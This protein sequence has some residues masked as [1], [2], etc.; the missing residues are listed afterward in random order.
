MTNDVIKGK[1]ILIIPAS[2]Q[3]YTIVEIAK[4]MGLYTIV[5]DYYDEEK[6]PAKKIAD[7]AY[8]ISWTDLDALEKLCREKQV[9]GVFSGFSESTIMYAAKLSERLGTPY[10]ATVEQLEIMSDKSKFKELCRKNGIKVV[11]EYQVDLS[12]ID[13]SIQNQNIRYPVCVKP[14]DSAG[15]RGIT[16]AY[17]ADSLKK[18]I[19][20]ALTFSASKNV[21]VEQYMTGQ[22]SCLTYTLQNGEIVLSTMSDAQLSNTEKG[23]LNLP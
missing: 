10:Y 21:V 17:D 18:S 2:R 23:H 3:M 12:D 16:V 22:E 13:G 11:E 6:S 19:E 1:R 9:D 7:E 5:S 14:V 15:S 4:R 20:Y 8:N